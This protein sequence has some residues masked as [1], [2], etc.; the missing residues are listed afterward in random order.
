M[1]DLY[2]DVRDFHLKFGLIPVSTTP[3]ILTLEEWAFRFRFML[4]ELIEWDLAI[5]QG[6]LVKAADSLVD[7]T[8]VVLG[9]ALMQNIPFNEVWNEVQKANMSKVRVT[10]ESESKRSSSLDVIKPIGWVSPESKIADILKAE[11][12]KNV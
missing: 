9:T 8:Y 3:R 12:L 10:H 7:L 2:K 4:E 11:M 6:D 1:A 5:R